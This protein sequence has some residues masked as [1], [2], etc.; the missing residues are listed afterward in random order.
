MKNA[1]VIT[2][3]E[4]VI[5]CVK[6]MK[7][8]NIF[9]QTVREFENEG[10][11]NYSEYNMG[12]L[13]WLTEDMKKEVKEFEEK[14]NAVV[15]HV[16]H[17]MTEFGELLTFL[18]VDENTDEW[19]REKHDLQERDPNGVYITIAY[20][21]NLNDPDFSEFGTVGIKPILGGIKRMY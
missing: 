1:K 8:L 6:R 21:R 13:Y 2:R 20:V 3:E 18:Y 12:I 5:E 4:K 19:E 16:I 10:V 11:V 9:P 17:N 15:Y 14:Y 7:L